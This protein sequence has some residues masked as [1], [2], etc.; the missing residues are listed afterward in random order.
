[1]R[2]RVRAGADL[3]HVQVDGL[4]LAPDAAHRVDGDLGEEVR[5]LR[6]HL[7]RVRARVRVRVRVRVVTN[8]NLRAQ[9]GGGD[10][11]EQVAVQGVLLLAGR[12]EHLQRLCLGE[13]DAVA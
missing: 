2:V 9:R 7:V 4:A 12:V 11:D 3:D 5:E 8:A 10:L 1:V 13:L 6:V